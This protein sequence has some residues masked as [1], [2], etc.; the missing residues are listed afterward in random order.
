MLPEMV[1]VTLTPVKTPDMKLDE[2]PENPP[3]PPKV[4]VP[5]KP[6]AVA[7]ETSFAVIV[8]PVIAVPTVWGEAIAE[9]SK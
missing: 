2:V 7:L 9:M 5:L 3:V 6:V 1:G 4:T 8:M